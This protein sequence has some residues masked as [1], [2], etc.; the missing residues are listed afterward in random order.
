M[1]DKTIDFYVDKYAVEI[2]RFLEMNGPTKRAILD[3]HIPI[4]KIR[5]NRLAYIIA[6]KRLEAAGLITI[7]RHI[8][9]PYPLTDYETVFFLPNH[10]AAPP[11]IKAVELECVA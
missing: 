7:A 6:Y 2:T 8:N 4:L 5:V 1:K 9:V 10:L 3:K 11:E